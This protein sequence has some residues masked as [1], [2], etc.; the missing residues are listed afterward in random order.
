MAEKRVYK[1]VI[2]E[3]GRFNKNK[4]MYQSYNPTSLKSILRKVPFSQVNIPLYSYQNLLIDNDKIGGNRVVGYVEGYN[5]ETD[6]FN[7]T[8]HEQY[9]PVVQ[10][11]KDPIIFIRAQIIGNKIV[12]ILGFDICPNMYYSLIR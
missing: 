4:T 6:T 3:V 12:K 5:E 11:F 9:G 8:I 1:N 7:V 10:E 2:M